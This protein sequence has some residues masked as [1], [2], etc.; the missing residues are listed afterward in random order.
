[1]LV[2]VAQR[3][4]TLA[5]RLAVVAMLSVTVSLVSVTAQ[6]TTVKYSDDVTSQ[7]DMTSSERVLKSALS[8]MTEQPP[9]AGFGFTSAVNSSAG[10][11][12]VHRIGIIPSISDEKTTA[13]L[14]MLE[15]ENII[16]ER[17]DM[18][19]ALPG[20]MEGYRTAIQEVRSQ[21]V[22]AV[23]GPFHL[24]YSAACLHLRV[25][26]LVTSQVPVS[27]KGNA[28][29]IELFPNYD[30]FSQSVLDILCYYHFRKAAVIYD[31]PAGA[32]ILEKLLG[33]TEMVVTGY[34]VDGHNV[35]R[36]RQA[37]KSMRD[38][39]FV[40]YVTVLS[41][42]VTVDVLD[43]A[44]SLSMF[45]TPTYKWILVNT[46]LQEFS[47]EKYVDSR[48][49]ITV[50]RLMMD[51]DSRSCTLEPEVINL[52][53]AILHDAVS[54]YV[55][56]DFERRNMSTFSMRRTNRQLNVEGCTGHLKFTRFGRRKESFLQLM[57]LQGYRSGKSG[58]WRS[59]PL[60]L[61]HR[62]VPSQSFSTVARLSQ[63]VFGD[64]PL[65]ITTLIEKPFVQYR[66]DTRGWRAGGVI[67]ETTGREL[68]GM[69]IDILRELVAK[70]GFSFRI[71]LV[72]DGKYGSKKDPP[73][74]WT[75][76]VRELKDDKADVA[77]APFQMSEIR[78]TVVDF[79]KPFMTKGTTV[80]VRRPEQHLWIFQFLSP[81]SHVVWSAIFVAFVIVSLTLFGVSRVN[82]DRQ[83][84]YTSNLRESFWYIWGTLLRGSLNGS[85]HA[86]SSR[87]VSSA[88]W[89]FCLIVTSIYT[90]NLAAF[91]TITIGDVGI[92]SAADLARQ[93][94]YDYGTVDG[95]QT[96]T[97]FNHTRMEDYAKMWAHMST[98]SPQSMVRRVENGFERVR[99]G[100]YAFIWD[101]PTVRHEI[102]NDCDLME[103]GASFDNKGY[104]FATQH[105]A[106]FAEKLSW[107]LLKLNDDGILYKLERKWWRPQFCPN[108]RQSAK[109]K[110]LNLETVAGMYLVLLA[111]IGMAV[112][113]CLLQFCVV[114][115]RGKSRHQNR[116]ND[117]DDLARCQ[118]PC[119][120][121]STDVST[122]SPENLQVYANHSPYGFRTTYST[123]QW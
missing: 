74:G 32:A 42:D 119:L 76:M 56:I 123:A 72:K 41:S 2:N 36:V 8:L 62:V 37:L 30:V 48:A 101:T 19:S 78:S 91:L 122:A 49:N 77:L 38:Q 18:T 6:V 87:I 115:C 54:V 102:S 52:R 93:D 21:E 103:I 120:K 9:G 94:L 26:Y 27:E 89:F 75:G 39:Y 31:S 67:E 11:P 23:I 10:P 35:S 47:L 57:T 116:R 22:R 20:T 98:L 12:E 109:T 3:M 5:R 25:P 53:R 40:S 96:Q 106:P 44:L 4:K 28:F 108:Q 64:R 29:L 59:S 86:I 80:V 7:D 34:R 111:G 73:R 117:A 110:S 90:A 33:E 118:E 45:S 66:E 24:E 100:G 113:L 79:T 105:H 58:T 88:W 82:S 99:Q 61:W 71:S 112:C 114:R 46:E 83:A 16:F 50:L 60:E 104:A 121:T 85:P 1:M 63:N 51:Y 70:L 92:N 81:L 84:K 107:A 95:S 97:F 17:V 55:M 68:E 69:C 65:R 14:S 43:Q 15:T 13:I